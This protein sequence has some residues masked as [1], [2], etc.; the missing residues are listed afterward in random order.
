MLAVTKKTAEEV[1]EK[2]IGANDANVKITEACEEYRPV[3]HRAAILYFL[4]AQF[5]NVNCMY[6]T[7]LKQFNELYELAIDKSDKAAMPSK[8]IGNIIESFCV[9]S[10]PRL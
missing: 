2:L 8:R 4:I 5:T 6:Q 3:A 10:I 9:Y 1:N 7:S